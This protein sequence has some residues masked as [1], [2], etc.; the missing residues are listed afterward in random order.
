MQVATQNECGALATLSKLKCGAG[1]VCSISCDLDAG[2]ASCMRSLA[3]SVHVDPAFSFECAEVW[4]MSVSCV[5]QKD[6]D[7]DEGAAWFRGLCRSSGCWNKFWFAALSRLACTNVLPMGRPVAASTMRY[8][9]LEVK[10]WGVGDV[11]TSV[12][13][14]GLAGVLRRV[15]VE[16]SIIMRR[17]RCS[18]VGSICR[19]DV[20]PSQKNLNVA[21]MLHR[22]VI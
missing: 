5:L 4:F 3:C 21:F 11:S 16:V 17:R 14:G 12:A 10:C 1:E 6:C 13:A 20:A 15:S 19:T 7:R 2:D 8:R 18:V 22:S 9:P